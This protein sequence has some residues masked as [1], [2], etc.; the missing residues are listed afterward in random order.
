MIG[1]A[2]TFD[3]VKVEPLTLCFH[4]M[5]SSMMTSNDDNL[6]QLSICMKQHLNEFD[7]VDKRMKKV[8]ND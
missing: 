2:S 1:D 5:T 8:T 7:K 6:L 4:K 3:D